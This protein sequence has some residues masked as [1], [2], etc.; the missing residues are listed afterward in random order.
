MKQ[1]IRF[2]ITATVLGLSLFS[3]AAFAH[4]KGDFFLRLNGYVNDPQV[5]SSV[6]STTL[7]A[8]PAARV[9]IGSDSGFGGSL[10]YMVDD[11][12]GISVQVATPS[13]HDLRVEGM[14]FVRLGR[15]KLVSPA[16]TFD[17]YPNLLDTPFQPFVGVGAAFNKIYSKKVNA[18]YL[19]AV[20]N[21]PT[22]LDMKSKFGIK[23][24]VGF[25]YH[26]INQWFVHASASYQYLNSNVKLSTAPVVAPALPAQMTT[27]SVDINPIVYNLGFAYKY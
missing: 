3:Q 21:A 10:N 2:G 27:A 25:D 6:V 24:I 9:K 19:A 4:Q 26:I 17:F 8:F 18:Q 12:M 23:G 1:V 13:R 7:G 5:R 14:P 22:G 15:F 16:V 11:H 20:G